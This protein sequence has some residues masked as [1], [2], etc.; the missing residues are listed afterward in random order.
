MTN[1]WW[2]YAAV[3][4]CVAALAV[5]A[6]PAAAERVTYIH[7]DALNSPVVGTD[8]AGEVLWQE[9]YRPY[10]DRERLTGDGNNS[11]WFTGKA[12]DPDT[13]LVYMGA[14]YYNPLL[15]RFI[16]IDPAPIDDGDP[17]SV[18]RYSYAA[19]N[20]F[21]YVDPDGREIRIAGATAD[22][23]QFID[24]AYR[25]TGFRLKNDGGNLVATGARNAAVGSKYA[26]RVLSLALSSTDV[27]DVTVVRDKPGVIV[28]SFYTSELDVADLASF[29]RKSNTLG[30]AVLTHVINERAY[31][32]SQGAGYLDSHLSAL[33][34]ESRVMG[35][36]SRVESAYPAYVP[37]GVLTFDYFDSTGRLKYRYQFGIDANRTPQ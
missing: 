19:N 1:I 28:D 22:V 13:L 32:V 8:S 12:Q 37:N 15:G 14:R 21:G 23:T 18:N 4:G 29:F 9:Y 24:Q 3:W 27:I 16:S 11:V 31:S 2:R 25:A 33:A 20:P 34:A 6:G 17:R 30:A 36:T 35:V 26:A 7:T 10:G 5:A